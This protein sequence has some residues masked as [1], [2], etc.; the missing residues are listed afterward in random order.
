MYLFE[1]SN[2]RTKLRNVAAM[3]LL[4]ILSTGCGGGGNSGTQAANFVLNTNTLMFTAASPS[5]PAPAPQTVT[6]SVSGTL[7][8]TLFV[9]I[10]VLSGT[11]V[12]SVSNV[13]LTGGNSGQATVTPAAPSVLGAGTFASMLRVRACLNDATCATGQLSGSPQTI[14]VT[15][16][17]NPAGS[18]STPTVTIAANPTSVVSGGSTTLTWASTNATGCVASGGWSGNKN[19][20]GNQP[21]GSITSPSSFILTCSGSG[22]TAAATAN[23]TIT[24][25][26]GSY[27]T[28]FTLTES[29]ISEGGVW[30]RTTTNGFTNVVT[31]GGA[32]FGTNGPRNAFD[33]SY[34][35]LRGFGPNQT[36]EAV[37]QRTEPLNTGVTHEVEL[38][39][40]FTDD[41]TTARGYECLFSFDGGVQ[42]IRWDGLNLGSMNFEDITGP[43]LATRTP[44]KTSDV[45]KA[46]IS[47]NVITVFINN[48]RFATATDSTYPT[49]QPGIGF[50]TRPQGNSA[51]LAITSYKVTSN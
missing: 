13:V 48:T 20:S 6:A 4:G 14:N 43:L 2:H 27:Q 33:D 28:D 36:A 31:A 11:N 46:S 37:I 39:L 22:G 25:A 42:I 34:A 44:L 29:P 47:G 49:G 23:V 21:I 10:E 12:V 7:S 8:G 45:V 32:A 50:F 18:G 41:V 40:R 51:N 5:A 1:H 38:L 30:S 17:V 19:T 16:I 15:Y 24:P 26:A 3:L 35:L 9:L